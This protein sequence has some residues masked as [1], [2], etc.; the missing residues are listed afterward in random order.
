MKNKIPCEK[1]LT[2]PICF[3]KYCRSP[4]MHTIGKIANEKCSILKKFISMNKSKS[5]YHILTDLNKMRSVI[6]FY[7]N[8][9]VKRGLA[10]INILM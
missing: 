10:L 7:H 9:R 6:K 1:C 3:S 5:N 8:E 2:F 4:G